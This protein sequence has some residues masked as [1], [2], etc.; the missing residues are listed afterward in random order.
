M[1]KRWQTLPSPRKN[2]DFTQLTKQ[3]DTTS[4]N[5]QHQFKK[6]SP[7]VSLTESS[8]GKNLNFKLYKYLLVDDPRS[9]S[10]SPSS[11]LKSPKQKQAFNQTKHS[12]II[13]KLQNYVENKGTFLEKAP[14]IRLTHKK[15]ETLENIKNNLM[16]DHNKFIE[17][18]TQIKDQIKQSKQRN[19]S[20]S[21]SKD[22]SLPSFRIMDKSID[23]SNIFRYS[24][25][26]SKRDNFCLLTEREHKDKMNLNLQKN[27]NE[28][29]HTFEFKDKDPLIQQEYNLAIKDKEYIEKKYKTLLKEHLLMK[30]DKSNL[31][32]KYNILKQE[33]IQLSNKNSI[34]INDKTNLEHKL[35]DG[36]EKLLNENKLLNK[37]VITQKQQNNYLSNKYK[38]LLTLNTNIEEKY[39]SLTKK[40]FPEN[41]F[42]EEI[43]SNLESKLDALQFD[44]KHLLI[45]NKNLQNMKETHKQKFETI[46]NIVSLKEKEINNLK[47]KNRTINKNTDIR[48]YSSSNGKNEDLM[49]TILEMEKDSKELLQQ[50]IKLIEEVNLLNEINSKIKTD[51]SSKE[52]TI[53]TL[54]TEIKNYETKYKELAHL[55]ELC[56]SRLNVSLSEIEKYKKEINMLKE[57]LPRK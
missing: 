47:K 42:Y 31:E 51:L 53:V 4:N 17:G 14:Q 9:N 12:E 49:K 27:I 33:N 32:Q 30:E 21:K 2:L 40:Q 25:P 29:E 37:I 50:N 36:Y 45:Q 8:E 15:A 3:P 13:N 24:N 7:L 18:I 43:I 44:Y 41:K 55:N 10:N 19:E 52:S 20:F 48:N 1:H 54:Q 35:G 34:L 16:K 46:K 11:N 23:N 38:N 26:I 57:Q 39:S 6:S 5:N 28:K 22:T 56:K